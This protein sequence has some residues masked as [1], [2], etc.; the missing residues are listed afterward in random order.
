MHL[1][2]LKETPQLDCLADLY[3][4]MLDKCS[5]ANYLFNDI[6]MWAWLPRLTFGRAP[7]MKRKSVVERVSQ[8]IRGESY[9]NYMLPKKK[10][11]KLSAERDMVNSWL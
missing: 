5:V 8:C 7:P 6:E 10:I 2:A 9:K 1:R 4:I 11:I 3:T